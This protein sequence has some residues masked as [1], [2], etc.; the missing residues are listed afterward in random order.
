MPDSLPSEAVDGPGFPGIP[1]LPFVPLTKAL[2]DP[3]RWAILRELAAGE[4]LMVVEIAKKVGTLVSKHLAI[5]RKLGLAA[6]K[7]RLYLMPPQ[8][9]SDPKKRV[10]DLG[11]CVLRLDTTPE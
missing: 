5:L 2:G 11:Y 9:I 7:Q 1:A 8:F 6:V 10:L 4:P 3:L